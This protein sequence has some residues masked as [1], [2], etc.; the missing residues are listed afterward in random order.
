MPRGAKTQS[1][2][3]PF[4]VDM[5]FDLDLDGEDANDDILAP[6]F[7]GF[8][9]PPDPYDKEFD[10]DETFIDAVNQENASIGKDLQKAD[11][12]VSLLLQTKK[13]VDS[14]TDSDYYLVIVFVSEEQ[15]LEFVDKVDWAQYGGSRFLNGVLLARAMGIELQP[16]Y[17]AVSSN[18]DKQLA[19]RSKSHG[20][21]QK[22]ISKKDGS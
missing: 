1:S 20:Q 2:D 3:D 14:G 9:T 12:Q 17:L 21:S 22:E 16:A 4:E 18:P 5:D 8:Y 6:V 10:E 13:V 7:K 15:K 19:E 11:E